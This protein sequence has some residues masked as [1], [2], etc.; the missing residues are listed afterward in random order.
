[1][2]AHLLPGGLFLCPKHCKKL[3]IWALCGNREY[4][5]I[6]CVQMNLH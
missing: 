2:I 5:S 4:A 1:M 6:A 3:T